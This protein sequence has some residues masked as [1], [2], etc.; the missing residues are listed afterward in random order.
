MARD[1]TL[2]WALRSVCKFTCGYC[3]FG[4]IAAHRA[5]V[6]TAPGT[7]SHLRRDD[8]TREEIFAFARSLDGS[9]VARVVI[10]GGEP[11]DWPH[12]LDLIAT[13]KAVGCQVVIA[14]NGVPLTKPIVASRLVELGVDAVSVSLD[15]TDA[16][17]N[18]ELRPALGGYAAHSDVL[19]GIRTLIDARGEAAAPRVGIYSVISRRTLDQIG[20]MAELA[21]ELGCDYYVPQ[22]VS[23]SPDHA[24]DEELT[25]YGHEVDRIAAGL[26]NLHTAGLPLA[27][28]DTHYT[29]LFIA[30]IT[31]RTPRRVE[32][33]FGGAQLFFAQPNGSL[34][35]C[36][37][38]LR[39]AATPPDRHRSIKGADARTLFADRP[40]CTDCALLGRDCVSMFPLVRSLPQ[41]LHLT[42]VR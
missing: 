6:P 8:L 14:T 25:P 15:S 34:W 36:P 41:M 5:Q 9:P 40:A 22:P 39:I 26:T 37:S 24:L 13:V 3:Y 11:L 4:T 20:A 7:L 38:D 21:V 1:I 17:A 12:I 42:E 23:L 33:C 35:D 19:C 32:D 16:A 29:R 31:D 10:A 28:P 27:L 18:D 2:L 30:S